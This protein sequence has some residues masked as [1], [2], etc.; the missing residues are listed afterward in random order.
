M[1]GDA[2]Y[3]HF[4]GEELKLKNDLIK[5]LK[6]GDRSL[7][8]DHLL[9]CP[10]LFDAL[11]ICESGLSERLEWDA[12]N[13]RYIK[14][15]NENGSKYGIGKMVANFLRRTKTIVV[16]TKGFGSQSKTLGGEINGHW[17][18]GE[19]ALIG[20]KKEK[21][22]MRQFNAVW[23]SEDLKKSPAAIALILAHEVGHGLAE[24]YRANFPLSYNDEE[25]KKPPYS[26]FPIKMEYDDDMWCYPF[27]GMMA[28]EL[29]ITTMKE[30]HLYTGESVKI[31]HLAK[32]WYEKII[33]SMGIK[34]P[35]FYHRMR[36]NTCLQRKLEYLSKGHKCGMR[37]KYFNEY[38]F[39]DNPVKVPPCHLWQTHLES[40][41]QLDTVLSE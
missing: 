6:T 19:I 5:A 26:H 7:Y 22:K 32:I 39:C 35:R 13:L 15:K 2:A 27:E 33:G 9:N 18:E 38:G 30:M 40:W 1:F 11:E 23:I 28:E 41:Y 24:E 10:A 17:E 34:F 8:E 20:N 12:Q 21:Y 14:V 3:P 4:S 29:G 31:E 36:I 16:F 37:C 25:L